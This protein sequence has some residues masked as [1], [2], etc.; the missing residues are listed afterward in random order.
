MEPLPELNAQQIADEIDDEENFRVQ[1]TKLEEQLNRMKPNLAAI[2]E[3]RKKVICP[4][5]NISDL[6][7]VVFHASN[8]INLS[9]LIH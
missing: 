8:S 3:Y 2:A 7:T 9:L 4:S 5:C 1:I 6:I